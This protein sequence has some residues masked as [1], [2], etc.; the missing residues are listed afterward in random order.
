MSNKIEL[1]KP[2]PNPESV[3]LI[4]LDEMWHFVQKKQKSCG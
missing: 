1:Q 3:S 4:S 2:N